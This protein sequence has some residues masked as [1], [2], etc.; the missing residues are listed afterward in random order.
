MKKIVYLIVLS[1]FHTGHAEDIYLDSIGICYLGNLGQI[2]KVLKVPGEARLSSW[3]RQE[4]LP[5]QQLRLHALRQVNL[6]T[7]MQNGCKMVRI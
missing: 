4:I 3:Q 1:L 6:W 7:C 5:F 2:G